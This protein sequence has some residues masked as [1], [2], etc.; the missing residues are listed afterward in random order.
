M[1]TYDVELTVS[2][3][4]TS[5]REAAEMV[6]Q[7]LARGGMYDLEITDSVEVR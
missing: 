4:A 3:K 6:A 7:V 2:L 1:K 5:A